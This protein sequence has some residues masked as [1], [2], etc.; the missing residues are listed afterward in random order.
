V[1]PRDERRRAAGLLDDVEIEAKPRS[2]AG[3]KAGAPADKAG[4]TGQVDAKQTSEVATDTKNG[5]AR[6]A[7]SRMAVGSGSR[8]S[9]L[10]R[11]THPSIANSN[12]QSNATVAG[13]L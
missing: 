8:V 6:K 1:P 4:S 5:R 13:D 7:G 12:I 11:T 9:P 3:K 2:V 10:R